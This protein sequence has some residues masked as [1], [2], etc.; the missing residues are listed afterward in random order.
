MWRTAYTL[1]Y[2]Y[3]WQG[4]AL[5]TVSIGIAIGITLLMAR[6]VAAVG[7]RGLKVSWFVLVALLTLALAV[8]HTAIDRLLYTC[9]RSGW[10]LQPIARDEY[11]QILSVNAWVFFS[12]TGFFIVILQFSRLRERE[13]AIQELTQVAKD[14]KLQT[15]MQQLNPHFLFNTLNSLGAL[16]ADQ[17]THDADRM[18][19]R[20]GRFLR[21]VI[22]ADHEDKIVLSS[23]FAMVRDYLAIQKVRFEDRLDFKIDL[24]ADCEEA[25]LPVLILQPIIENAVK[26]GQ[27]RKT[28]VCHVSI[29]ARRHRDRLVLTIVDNG[30]GFSNLSDIDA[31]AGLSLIRERLSTHYGQEAQLMLSNS[32]AKGAMITIS[33][34]CEIEQS[35]GLEHRA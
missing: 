30:P 1:A 16:I 10:T 25:M 24:P 28:A 22:D 13:R 6:V 31:G 34:P 17:R 21:H 8:V 15:L 9:A 7:P 29:S 26:H 32:N 27:N 23:E 4:A 5:R 11:I 33:V 20:L 19:V 35:F 18:L 2:G 12:W 14:A 3:G